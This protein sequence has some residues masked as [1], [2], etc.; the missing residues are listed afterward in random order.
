M[1]E[2]KM[3][4]IKF[5]TNAIGKSKEMYYWLDSIEQNIMRNPIKSKIDMEDRIPMIHHMNDEISKLNEVLTTMYS[6]LMGL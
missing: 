6:V 4:Y 2:D 5:L 3:E 1:I